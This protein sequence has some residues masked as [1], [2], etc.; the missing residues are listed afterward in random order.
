[1]ILFYQSTPLML[2][3]IYSDNLIGISPLSIIRNELISGKLIA[4]KSEISLPKAVMY[5]S[6]IKRLEN[7][8]IREVINFFKEHNFL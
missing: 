2:A 3:K 7:K 8:K 6:Y 1:M 5:I 4:I